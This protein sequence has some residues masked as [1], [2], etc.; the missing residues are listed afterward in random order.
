MLSYAT[1]FIEYKEYAN[2]I[3]NLPTKKQNSFLLV[4]IKGTHYW[5]FELFWTRKELPLNL[6]KPENNS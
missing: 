3:L 4:V 5:H 2:V 6:R 1:I